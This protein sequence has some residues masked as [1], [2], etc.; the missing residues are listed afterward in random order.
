MTKTYT[1]FCSQFFCM[2]YLLVG[3]CIQN[4]LSATQ[5]YWRL[6]YHCKRNYSQSMIAS[7]QQTVP[8]SHMRVSVALTNAVVLNL[9]T[10]VFR[11]MRI[12][13]MYWKFMIT[14][15]DWLKVITILT[16]NRGNLSFISKSLLLGF[17]LNISEWT[18]GFFIFQFHVSRYTLNLRWVVP[19][20]FTIESDSDVN[21]RRQHFFLKTSREEIPKSVKFGK[22]DSLEN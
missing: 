10:F 6:I 1:F 22:N 21:A 20:A 16:F 12:E 7:L 2:Q 3:H 8:S 9:H 18:Q 15:H 17:T 13:K 19:S 11:M 5:R 4:K 14:N